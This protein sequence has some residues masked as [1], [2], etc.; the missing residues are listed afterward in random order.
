MLR[1]YLRIFLKSSVLICLASFSLGLLAK[2]VY[3]N[4]ETKK[5]HDPGCRWAIKCTKNCIK[6]SEKDA[7]R[8]GGIACKVCGG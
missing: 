7:Q 8:R 1:K 5:Y 2:D 3:F 6:I 4:V